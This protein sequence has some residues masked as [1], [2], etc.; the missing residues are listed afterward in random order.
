VV[1]ICSFV[2]N[3]SQ[4]IMICMLKWKRVISS[5]PRIHVYEWIR[6]DQP[7]YTP[8]FYL[9]YYGATLF[10]ISLYAN[11]L[12]KLQLAKE[13][14]LK[15]FSSS[16]NNWGR[17]DCDFKVSSFCLFYTSVLLLSWSTSH[18]FWY[19]KDKKY[20]SAYFKIYFMITYLLGQFPYM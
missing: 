10:Q 12:V 13:K 17:E 8:L 16:R 6:V 3:P 14:N 19:F 20:P 18:L 2:I 7:L 9:I 5:L 15:Q 1:L 11:I 4:N